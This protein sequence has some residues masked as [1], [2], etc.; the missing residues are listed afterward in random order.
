[1][2]SLEGLVLFFSSVLSVRVDEGFG[3]WGVGS[4]IFGHNSVIS[5]SGSLCTGSSQPWPSLKNNFKQIFKIYIEENSYDRSKS[6]LKRTGFNFNTYYIHEPFN[7]HLPVKNGIPCRYTKKSL[8][9][10]PPCAS[11]VIVITEFAI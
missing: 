5:T 7:R 9:E 3:S 6:K 2:T 1:M 11:N 10:I 4:T 8:I